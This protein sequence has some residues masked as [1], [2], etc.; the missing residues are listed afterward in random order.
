[1]PLLNLSQGRGAKPKEYQKFNPFSLGRRGL[2]EE[3]INKKSL[4]NRTSFS[5]L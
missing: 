3:A 4:C 5:F 1:M 2:G